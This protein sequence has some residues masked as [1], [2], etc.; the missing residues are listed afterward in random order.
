ME[1]VP[2]LNFKNE[3][4]KS[5]PNFFE[6]IRNKRLALSFT[7]LASFLTACENSKFDETREYHYDK[8]NSIEVSDEYIEKELDHLKLDMDSFYNEVDEMHNLSEKSGSESEKIDEEWEKNSS[9]SYKDGV[10]IQYTRK[11]DQGDSSS[12]N[13]FRVYYL[14]D[15]SR[16]LVQQSSSYDHGSGSEKFGEGLDYEIKPNSYKKAISS[17]SSRKVH[18]ILEEARN[19]NAKLALVREVNQKIK[20]IRSKYHEYKNKK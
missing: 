20:E 9:S 6:R 16:I 18:R 14:R 19:N 7:Y 4:K 13:L 8:A 5:L 12:E 11:F 17:G 1:T 10:D 3:Q 15:D 2:N